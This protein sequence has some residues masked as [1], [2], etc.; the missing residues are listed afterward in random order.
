MSKKQRT[1]FT[2]KTIDHTKPQPIR[3]GN[4]AS[5]AAADRVRV[6]IGSQYD[7]VYRCIREGGERGR[8]DNEIQTITQISG[9][10][11]RP[12]RLQL[13]ERGYIRA[14][15]G[16]GLVPIFRQ[17]CTVWVTTD[18]PWPGDTAANCGSGEAST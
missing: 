7:R 18:K 8:T 16:P 6:V 1:L 13:A 17:G 3:N 5:D 11:E 15:M 14:A 4:A 10:S 2:G 9:D 12:R